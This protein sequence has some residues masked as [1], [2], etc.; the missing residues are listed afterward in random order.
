M[1]SCPY[2]TVKNSN[3]VNFC[4]QCFKQI[5]CLN[6]EC[7]SPLTANAPICL[8][9]GKAAKAAEQ[10]AAAPMNEFT[11][12]IHQTQKSYREVTKIRASDA[13][14]G[15][16]APYVGGAP[17]R[18]ARFHIASPNVVHDDQ[19]STTPLF[20]TSEEAQLPPAPPAIT[21]P[22]PVPNLN[23]DKAL[24]LQF[25]EVTSDDE[26]TPTEVDFKGVTRKEQLCRFLMTYV[27]A[28]VHILGKPVPSSEHLLSAAKRSGLYDANY[29]KYFGPTVQQYMQVVEGNYKL[30]PA[31]TVEAKRIFSEM[32][33]SGLEGFTYW[34][35]NSKPGRKNTRLKSDEQMKIEEWL[36]RPV[37]IGALDVRTLTPTQQAIFAVWSLT[38]ALQ[39]VQAVKPRMAF[40]YM[41][42]KY[43]TVSGDVKAF[44]KAFSRP[45]NVKYFGKNADGLYYLKDA[46]EKAVGGWIGGA[47]I[48]ADD[49]KRD[50]SGAEKG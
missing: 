44:V 25:F 15:Q 38:K 20:E 5:K 36:I 12:E 13:V 34:K 43:T 9:C 35:S 23:D 18:T 40:E 10:G 31:G 19:V 29:S 37:T 22:T 26:L 32:Q 41:A 42:K 2:C 48:T 33:N 4:A 24:A 7:S 3:A 49:T 39:V 30:K 28:Y 6:S 1:I 47:I 11:R 46:A 27:W 14:A 8:V 16:Y 50:N 45:G 21:E 17:G